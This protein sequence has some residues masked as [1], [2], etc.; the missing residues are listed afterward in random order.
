MG[1]APLSILG[2]RASGG[3]ATVR[4][5]AWNRVAVRVAVWAPPTAAEAAPDLSETSSD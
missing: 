2:P 4:C 5:C 1:A 3:L